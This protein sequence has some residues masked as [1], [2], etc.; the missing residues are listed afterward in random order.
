MPCRLHPHVFFMSSRR[1]TR[2]H[3]HV[4]PIHMTVLN[5]NAFRMLFA[6][7]CLP[8][9]LHPHVFHMSSVR[10][11]FRCFVTLCLARRL[12]LSAPSHPHPHLHPHHLYVASIAPILWRSRGLFVCVL[13][14]SYL[15]LMCD[16]CASYV[17]LV[18]V[19]AQIGH[20][21]DGSWCPI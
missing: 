15:C 18:F 19:L 17:C 9:L 10:F 16:L 7:T 8:T 3:P 14:A 12:Y 5:P 1:L 2:L 11:P 13:N 4:F 20:G 21:S 6:S